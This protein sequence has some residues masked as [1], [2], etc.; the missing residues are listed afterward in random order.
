[1][2]TQ[3]LFYGEALCTLRAGKV[4]LSSVK[5]MCCTRFGL[6]VNLFVQRRKFSPV[7]IVMWFS[8]LFLYWETLSTLLEGER[9]LSSVNSHVTIKVD[10]VWNSLHTESRWKTFSPVWTLMWLLRCWCCVKLT[11]HCWQVN[12][13]SPVW[14]LMWFFSP[15]CREKL[16]WPYVPFVPDASW[17]GFLYCLKYLGFGFVCVCRLIGVWHRFLMFPYELKQ[18]RNPGQDF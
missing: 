6:Y 5:F 13:F 9:L 8:R 11:P 18:Y 14:I 12:G 2:W 17:P 15:P 4:F 7:W 16:G 3:G 10:A 1:M